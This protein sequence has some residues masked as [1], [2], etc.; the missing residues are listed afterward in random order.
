MGHDSGPMTACT[1]TAG[2]HHAFACLTHALEVEEWFSRLTPT[3]VPVVTSLSRMYT[4]TALLPRRSSHGAH[5]N[6][7]VAHHLTAPAMHVQCDCRYYFKCCQT[8]L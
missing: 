7:K 2:G 4:A 6:A 5:P 8:E 3:V 1:T